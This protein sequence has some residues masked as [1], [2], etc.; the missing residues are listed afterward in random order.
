M[1]EFN[2]HRPNSLDEVRQLLGECEAPKILAGG[3]TLLPTLKFRLDQPS[4]LIDLGALSDLVSVDRNGDVLS[5]G[6]LTRHSVV[7][8]SAEV[9]SAI[10]A[11]AE[12]AETI[13]DPQVRNRGTLGGSI[14]NNDPAAD[15]PAALLALN[16]T[17]ETD[18]RKI[19]VDD[20][21][22]GMFEVALKA[23]E[24]IIGVHFSVPKRAAYCKFPNP[25]SRYALAAVMVAE[26]DSG[27]RIAVTGAGENGAFRHTEMEQALS[28]DFSANAIAD[29]GISSDGLNED[30]HA[31]SDYRAHLIRVM[32]QRAVEAATG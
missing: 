4:D 13:G 9:R 3:M 25:A 26:F 21:F 8:S 5:I 16:A 18:Q 27:V 17:V 7:A 12:L 29:I 28:Q 14:A 6:A 20:F 30:I 19:A 15:Y 22:Q 23:N 2:Y 1:Y 32:A 31:S 24:I 10:P 11:L